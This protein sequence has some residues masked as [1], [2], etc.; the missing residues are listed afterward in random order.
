MLRVVEHDRGVLFL[1][2]YGMWVVT[3]VMRSE[4]EHGYSQSW[5][6]H[7]DFGEGEVVD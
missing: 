6:L 7:P 2:R 4:D 5:N 1:R 3:D